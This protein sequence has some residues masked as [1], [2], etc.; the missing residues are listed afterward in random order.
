[1]D[2]RELLGAFGAAAAGMMATGAFAAPAGEGK[3]HHHHMDK[4]HEDC[5][6]ACA[7]CAKACN[8]MAHHCMDKI[9]DGGP[10]VKRHAKA[11]S[12]AMDCQAFCVLSA[13][14]IARGSDLMQ[15]SCESCADA[16]RRCAEE[17]EKPGGDAVMKSC[18][19]KCRACEKTCDEMVR[20]MKASSGLP[21]D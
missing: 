8:M 21:N 20:H 1:M 6:S 17:C 4:V 14:M 10:D 12:L 15:Y 13:S 18:G 11:H 3:D 7:D 16:C 2:R 19:E 5:L 9:I